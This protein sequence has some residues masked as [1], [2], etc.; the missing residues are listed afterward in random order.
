MSAFIRANVIMDLTGRMPYW[1]DTPAPN[2]WSHPWGVVGSHT[3]TIGNNKVNNFRYGFTRAAYSSQGDSGANSVV[4]RFIFQPLA[5][6]RT[7]SR[8]NPVHNIVDDF[9]WVRG[10][11][12][13]QFGINTRI[14]RNSRVN[15]GSAFDG[16][17][18][19][20]S[21]Y[22]NSGTIISDAIQAYLTK[23]NLPALQSVSESQNAA[24]A[25]IG[26]YTQYTANFTY[27]ANGK[28]LPS[29][30]P[31]DRTFATEEYDFYFQDAWRVTP[32]LT[33]TYGLRYGLS[34][35]VYETNGFEVA[36]QITLGDYFDRRI[37]GMNSG[38]PYNEPL[39]LNYSGPA[40]NKPPMYPWDKNNFQPRASVSWSPGFDSGILGK[41][42]GGRD[43]SVIRGGFAMTNDYFGQA[44]AVLFDTNNTLGFTSNT[45][46]SANTYNV[47][48]RP[49]PLFT[50]Y[51]QNVRSLPNIKVIDSISFPRQMPSDMQR[52]IEGGLDGRLHSPVNYQFNLTFER[53]LPAGMVLTASYIG[54]MGR[55]LLATRDPMTA[56]N[57]KDPKS[58]QD[59]FTA[60]TNLEKIRQTRAPATSAV[61]AQPFFDNTFP[62]NFRDIMESYGDYGL[63]QGLTPTQT[64]YWIMRSYYGNDWTYLQDDI[65]RA[66]NKGY[67]YQ[68]Q[69]GALAAW[70]TVANSNYGAMAISLRQRFRTSLQ[71]DFNYT[72]SHSLD[73][74]SGLQSDV[75]FGAG[76]IVNPLRQR[77]NYSNSDFDMRHIINVNSVYALPFGKGAAIGSTMPLWADAIV[78]GWQLS[79]IFRWNSGLPVS[80]PYDDARWATNWNVQSNANW[81]RPIQPCIT[82]GTQ[83]TAPKLFGCDPTYAY[84]SFRNAYPGEGGQR[85]IFRLPSYISLDAGLSKSFKL[86]WKEG[87]SLQLRW[88]VFNVTNTQRFGARDTSRTGY[89]LRLDPLVRNLAP[90]ANWSNFT[91]IQGNARVM[92]IGARLQF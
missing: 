86:P 50:G 88:E 70:S 2:T 89:G 23:N 77:E 82:K 34:R 84:Q 62:A 74:A 39:V 92:Q 4:F 14:I 44:L 56:N 80:P 66:F 1:P 55:D 25:L 10:S 60:A 65:D 32:N 35:P 57:L 83:T 68:P 87:Q 18:T 41:L 42:F 47:T 8:V 73:D 29:G 63:P 79:G 24:T 90:P 46:I 48:T 91:G 75:A 19:N 5:F 59:W 36:P 26:R 7:I 3:W 17:T 16:A 12:T 15:Y 85:N 13:Y 51:G 9:S 69:Y 49:P 45:T 43:R 61:P 76:F 58:G 31:T 28:L 33:L 52:R 21:F 40:N 27:G 67:F 38:T 81:I 72:L 30:T 78:G 54:R 22:Q 64:V 11:H 53:Q 71:W 6:S 37:A 20:P